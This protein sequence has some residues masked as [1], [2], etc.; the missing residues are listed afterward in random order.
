MLHRIPSLLLSVGVLPFLAN[1]VAAQ[2]KQEIIDNALSAAPAEI[3]AG[4]TVADWEGNVLRE[5]TNGYTCLPDD[6]DTPG[7]S[8]MCLD[9]TWTAWANAW[10]NHE[11]PPEVESVS[12]AYMLQGDFPTSNTDPYATEPTADNEWLEDAGPHIMILVPDASSLAGISDDPGRVVPYVMWK[13]TPYVHVMVP[14]AK[15]K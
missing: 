9:E 6:P 2:T 14:T 11:A 3:A 12:F 8:P 7:N 15:R 1:P 13:D 10:M 5:G 4:A